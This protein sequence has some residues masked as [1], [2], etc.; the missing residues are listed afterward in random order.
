MSQHCTESDDGMYNQ[1]RSRKPKYRGVSDCVH[2]YRCIDVKSRP[3]LT[4]S[5]AHRLS[6]SPGTGDR[7]TLAAD[8]GSSNWAITRWK[9]T[10]KSGRREWATAAG[11]TTRAASS[12]RVSLERSQSRLVRSERT[13]A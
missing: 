2:E 1:N 12:E 10:T 13:S 7:A 6:D 11:V 9:I 3:Y 8:G 5:C 4:R